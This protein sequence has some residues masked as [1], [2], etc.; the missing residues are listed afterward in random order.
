MTQVQSTYFTYATAHGPLT[1]RTTKRGVA[2]ISFSQAKLEGTYTASE[3]AN[4]AATQIQEYLAGKRQAFDVPLDMQGSAFQ[5]AVWTEL[6]AVPYGQT[7]TAAEIATAI[8]K[9]GSHRSVGTAIKQNKLA[10]LVPS[11]RVPAASATGRHA[12]LLRALQTLEQHNTQ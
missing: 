3:L 9:P 4:I 10:P 5:K 6:T 7:R 2:E 11:H 1:V 8:G 12:K